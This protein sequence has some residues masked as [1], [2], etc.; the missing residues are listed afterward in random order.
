MN[1]NIDREFKQAVEDGAFPAAQL[2][3]AKGGDVIYSAS[4]GQ[5]RDDTCF[6]IASL[7]KPIA[8]ATLT[9]MLV[10]DGLLKLDDTVYQWL[11]GARLPAH[12]Q[13]TVGQLLDHRSGLAAWQPFYRSLPMALV[14]TEE[15][16]H[17]MLEECYAEEPTGAPG[18]KTLYSDIGYIML[19]EIVEQAGGMR[20]DDLFA[21][22][23]A[24]PLGIANTFFVRVD[25]A[26]VNT[27]SRRTTTSPDQH[28]PTPKH[29]AQSRSRARKAGE[30]RR[31]APTEDCP[32]RDRVMHGEVH[33]QNAFALGGVA[34]H[35]GLFS[36]A[37]DVHRFALEIY[38]CYRGE[39]KVIPSDPMRCELGEPRQKP[40]TETY[41][42]GWNR[43]SRKNSSSGRSFSPN[44]IGHLAYTGCSLWMDLQRDFW[45]VLLTNRVHPTSTN[46]K[47]A[48]FRPR[49]H[50]VIFEELIG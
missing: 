14:G 12:R 26:A 5:A 9:T 44:S 21:Q 8:T 18:A 41:C 23:I 6:D 1:K 31:F 33:D 42:A 22:R 15:G 48:A 43:P 7:T 49:I 13:M 27:S 34:G 37:Q 2:C 10:H 30:H 20:L 24:R 16:K 36:T 4:Y 45:V 39:S 29:G 46:Q 50:D 35:A 25:Q 11:A 19:G 38:R 17:I 32:W 3:V 47:I 40:A 28:V